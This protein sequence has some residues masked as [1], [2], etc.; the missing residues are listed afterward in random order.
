MMLTS[1]SEYRQALERLSVLL[2]KDGMMNQTEYE[3]ALRLNE[4]VRDYEHIHFPEFWTRP[5]RPLPK[6]AMH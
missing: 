1:R 3:E 4:A 6:R 5:D 2:S